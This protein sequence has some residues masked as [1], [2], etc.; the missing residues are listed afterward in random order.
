MKDNSCKIYIHT[1]KC[2]NDT[3]EGCNYKEDTNNISNIIK[4]K[5]D[6]LNFAILKSSID[7]KIENIAKAHNADYITLVLKSWEIY[8]DNVKA[9]LCND[10][11]PNPNSDVEV[12]FPMYLLFGDIDRTV[13][14]LYNQKKNAV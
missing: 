11:L 8:G 3:C 14:M 6:F 10:Y 1:Y 12:T 13:K 7:Y 5:E 2:N 9:I 4:T